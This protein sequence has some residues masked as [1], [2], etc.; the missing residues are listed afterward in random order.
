[1]NRYGIDWSKLNGNNPTEE[2]LRQIQNETTKIIEDE[3]AD[4]HEKAIAYY[5]RG[6]VYSFNEESE[7]ELIDYTSAIS[8]DPTLAC[9]YNNRGNI[10]TNFAKYDEAIQDFNTALKIGS[11]YANAYYNRARA[12]WGKE[13]YDFAIEDFNKYLQFFPD[14]EQTKQNIENI[15]KEKNT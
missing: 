2:E 4:I 5:D 14:D 12:Y 1:M 10:Y 13:Q 3:K 11:K 7:K 6:V 8:L 15:L 9:A